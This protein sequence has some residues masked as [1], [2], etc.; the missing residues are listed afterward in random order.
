MEHN[1][2]TGLVKGKRDNGFLAGGTFGHF[3][4]SLADVL[5]I[6]VAL[7]L[8][9]VN[10]WEEPDRF[11]LLETAHTVAEEVEPLKVRQLRQ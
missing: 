3:L 9:R 8:F 10:F 11:L 2:R 4:V 6:D 5:T 1:G 7:H